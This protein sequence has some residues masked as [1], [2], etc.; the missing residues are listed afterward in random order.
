MSREI[1]ASTE[2]VGRSPTTQPEPEGDGAEPRTPRPSAD[3]GSVAF[4]FDDPYWDDVFD[5]WHDPTLRTC[6]RRF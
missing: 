6:C 1:P 5:A 2:H 4:R 3:P